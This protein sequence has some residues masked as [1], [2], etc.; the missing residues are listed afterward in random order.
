[1]YYGVLGKSPNWQTAL[2]LN[3]PPNQEFLVFSNYVGSGVCLVPGPLTGLS[4]KGFVQGLCLGSLC[5]VPPGFMCVGQFWI[6]LCSSDSLLYML[7]TCKHKDDE[8][9]CW[10]LSE[11]W[12]FLTFLEVAS[13]KNLKSF[14]MLFLK[15]SKW[16][17]RSC[18]SSGIVWCF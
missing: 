8:Y 17:C 3:S 4:M 11:V 9:V 16:K 1:M 18:R 10:R 12:K 2:L 6:F 13:F 5:P 14:S 7:F 15:S